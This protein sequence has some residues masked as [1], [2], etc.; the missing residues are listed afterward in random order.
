MNSTG[1][2]VLLQKTTLLGVIILVI[3]YVIGVLSQP[4]LSPEIGQAYLTLSAATSFKEV[5]HQFIK[6]DDIWYRPFPFY[7]TNFFIYKMITMRDIQFIKVFS[8]GFVFF[9]AYIVTVLAKKIF[10]SSLVERAILFSLVI[11]HPLYYAI[12]CDGTGLID[13]VFNI[14]VNLFLISYLTLLENSNNK[15]SATDLSKLTRSQVITSVFLCCLFM[16]CAVTSHERALAVFPM[17]GILFLY[18]SWQ[19]PRLKLEMNTTIVL[20]FGILIFSLYMIFVIGAAKIGWTGPV[21]RTSWEPIYVIPN[22][23]RA[24]EFPFRLMTVITGH[25]YDVHKEFWFNIFALPF[26]LLFLAYLF[27]VF[28]R[29][30]QQE[31][32]RLTIL[33]MLFLCS[34]AMPV[35]FGGNSWHFY[36]AALY[37]SIMMARACGYWVSVFVANRY[38]QSICVI[39]LFAWLTTSTVYGI[40][41]ELSVGGKTSFMLLIHSALEDKT[42]HDVPYTPQVVYYE[43]GD[44]EFKPVTWAFGGNGNLFKYLYNNP[45]IIEIALIHGKIYPENQY[46]CASTYLKRSLAFR[47]DPH[48]LSW[49]KIANKNYC[50]TNS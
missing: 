14:F 19:K 3:C 32:R 43:V 31:K 27:M 20:M 25:A 35:L 50:A 46:L 6:F 47:F 33:L 10:A 9:N 21:Y 36:T 48:D 1:S 28:F 42:L 13:P 12:I 18:Y 39:A 37:I 4:T 49:H 29:D 38:I 24:I 15:I 40:N 17:L 44:Y 41:Q 30:M 11:S 22:M 7:L 5:L 2:S 45:H 34:S 26:I 16:V 23:L 8:F